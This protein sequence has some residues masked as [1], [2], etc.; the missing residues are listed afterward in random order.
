MASDV[1]LIGDDYLRMLEVDANHNIAIVKLNKAAHM[2]SIT[3][4]RWIKQVSMKRAVRPRGADRGAGT[5][6]GMVHWR[7]V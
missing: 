7:E 2:N 4:Q 3:K 5:A 6:V 1:L